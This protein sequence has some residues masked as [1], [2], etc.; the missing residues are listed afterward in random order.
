MYERMKENGL[1][2]RA[3]SDTTASCLYCAPQDLAASLYVSWATAAESG[4]HTCAAQNLL[5]S[6]PRQGTQ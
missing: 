6:K 1:E 2:Q 5:S 4:L 3:P